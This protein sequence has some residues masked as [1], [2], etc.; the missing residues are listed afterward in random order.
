MEEFILESNI[1][2][3][4]IQAISF[5]EGVLEAHQ[6]LH[7]MVPFSRDRKYF[8][9]SRPENGIIV[10]KAATEETFANEAEKYNCQTLLLKKGK[11]ISIIVEHFR[12]NPQKIKDAFDQLIKHYDLAPEGYCV[13]WY[14]NVEDTVNC[15][16]R[17]RKQ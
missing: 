4:Y 6:K 1:K 3:F 8:G 16:I 7:N 5:P 13:E 10:Y 2:L 15:F 17:L 14:N 9:I 11:Y 12:E